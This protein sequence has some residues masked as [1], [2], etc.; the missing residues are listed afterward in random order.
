M[1]QGITPIVWWVRAQGIPYETE[2]RFHG[3]RRWR[4]DLALHHHRV[5][6]EYEGIHSAKSRHTSVTGYA[7][8]CQKYNEA[9]ILGWL[10]LRFTAEDIRTG[11]CYDCLQRAIEARE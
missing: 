1:P 7:K 2:Y 5:A 4:F 10:V 3:Q 9:Q 8:D 11:R 6:V